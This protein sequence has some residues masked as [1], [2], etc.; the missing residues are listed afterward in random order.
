MLH[1]DDAV[2]NK[3]AALYGRAEVRDFVDVFAVLGSGRYNTT[4]LMTLARAADP[5]FDVEMFRVALSALAR[6]PDQALGLHGL[7][8][9]EV[10]NLRRC[11]H[12]WETSLDR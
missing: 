2:G 4:Q 7:S 6:I 9:Q 11:F 10:V 1:P 8:P 12:D 3:V 5:G